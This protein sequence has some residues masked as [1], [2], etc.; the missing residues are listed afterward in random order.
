L[1]LIG[2]RRSLARAKAIKFFGDLIFELEKAVRNL[3]DRHRRRGKSSDT[4]PTS[5]IHVAARV[6]ILRHLAARAPRLPSRIELLALWSAIEILHSFAA[7]SRISRRRRRRLS[8]RI[9]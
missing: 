1:E 4:P 7:E 5:R 9:R 2:L 8:T 3:L 6:P